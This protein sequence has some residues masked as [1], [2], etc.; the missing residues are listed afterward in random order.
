MKQTNVH[1]AIW[2]LVLHDWKSARY[3]LSYQPLTGLNHSCFVQHMKLLGITK[4][5]LE[6][7]KFIGKLTLIKPVFQVPNFMLK[8]WRQ[9]V[10][11][12]EKRCSFYPLCFML[13]HS[14]NKGIAPLF[15][16][17]FDDSSPSPSFT[18]IHLTN[19]STKE[20]IKVDFSKKY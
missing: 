18:S 9:T 11:H 17:F 16:Y 14:F 7:R 8:M 1:A 4:Y 19:P 3:Q 15:V 6:Y 2:T 12:A 10:I 20:Y 13:H 5:N